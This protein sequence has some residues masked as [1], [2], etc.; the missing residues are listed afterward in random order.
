MKLKLALNPI[1]VMSYLKQ[2]WLY[3]RYLCDR[4]TALKFRQTYIPLVDGFRVLDFGCGRGR[5]AAMLTQ[6]GFEATGVDQTRF[7]WW[8]K[9][10]NKV[11]TSFSVGGTEHM[12]ILGAGYFDLCLCFLVLYL[13]DNDQGLLEQF[14]RVLRPGGYLV[15]QV[16]NADNLWTLRTGKYLNDYEPI[17]QYYTVKSLTEKVEKA[18]FRVERV[19][20]EKYYNPR[21]VKLVNAA[22]GLLP[23]CVGKWAEKRIPERNR[24][25]INLWARK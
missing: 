18:G 8:D 4:G 22:L 23:E 10:N 9:T 20:Y 7:K 13:V 2:E 5:H 21:H 1:N 11:R 3:N 24:G 16:P 6:L 14:H 17:K 19:W 15:L 25:A 12:T